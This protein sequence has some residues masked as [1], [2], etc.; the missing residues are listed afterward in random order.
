MNWYKNAL[1]K[2]ASAIPEISEQEAAE[3][4]LFGPVYHGT[5]SDKQAKIDAEAT[6]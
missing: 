2:E 4:K 3:R 1:Q 6:V 5:T